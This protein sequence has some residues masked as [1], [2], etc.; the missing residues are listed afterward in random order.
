MNRK[1]CLLV[2]LACIVTTA[3]SEDWPTWRHDPLRSGVSKEKLA[4]PLEEVWVFRSRQSGNAPVPTQAPQSFAYPW[5]MH[6]TL[7]ICS[8]GDSLFFNSAMDGRTV[9][10][11]VAT[12]NKRWEFMAAA[13]MNRTPTYYEERIYVGSDDGHVYC[14]DAG[15]GEL[16]WKFKAVQRNRWMLSYEKLTSTWPV[17]SDVVVDRGVAYFAAGILPHEGTFLFAVDAKTGKLIWCN[18]S[19]GAAMRREAIAPA[20][21]LIVS[22]KTIWVPRDHFGY[23]QNHGMLVSF[24]RETGNAVVNAIEDVPGFEGPICF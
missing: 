17:R 1:L 6:Y 7:P 13:A 5:G 24:E 3:H 22:E 12:G 20:G 16:I 15:T 18:A 21:H 19:Q 11:D 23:S 4:P 14:L 2:A 8:A 9:C 10:L